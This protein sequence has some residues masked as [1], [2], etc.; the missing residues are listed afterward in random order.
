GAETG[1]GA[2]TKGKPGKRRG[3]GKGCRGGKAGADNGKL[4]VV[5]PRSSYNFYLWRRMAQLKASNTVEKHRDRFGMAA[6]E[7]KSMTPEERQPF[8]KM[9]DEDKCRFRKDVLIAGVTSDPSL[10]KALRENGEGQRQPGG[11]P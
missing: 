10:A 2:W 4:R 1:A 7:W 11:W 8:E 9:A 6:G 3:A 5:K